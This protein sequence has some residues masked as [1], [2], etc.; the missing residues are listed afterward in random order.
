MT[1]VS[2][3]ADRLQLSKGTI[4][5]HF[6][7]KDQLL[8]QMSLAYMERRLGELEVIVEELPDHAQQLAGLIASLVTSYRDDRDASIAFSREFVR[9]ASEEVMADVRVLRRRYVAMLQSLLESGAASGSFRP[10]DAKIVALQIIGMCNWTWTWLRPD[11]R[12]SY[13][14]IADVFVSTVLSGVLA[15]SGEQ[16]AP[17]ALPDRVVELRR[18]AEA[19]RA[20]V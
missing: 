19:D 13:D 17:L 16:L 12:L 14:E 11:G 20:A 6:G 5:Y 8:R 1:S 4:M 10:I 2:E 7:S 3:I 18:A 15:G 9:F